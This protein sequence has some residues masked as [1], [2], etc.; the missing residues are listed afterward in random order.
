MTTTTGYGTWCN[1]ISPF[2]TSPEN[3]ILDYING[4]DPD[5]RERMETSGAL[6]RI[7]AEYRQAIEAALPP[8]ISLCGEEFIGPAHP[9]DGE[10][11]GYT[12]DEDGTVDLRALIEEIDLAAIIDRNDVDNA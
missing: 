4:G 8:G 6:D 9:E 5:W 11:D 10:F 7:S 1:R 12:D 3:D 2:S